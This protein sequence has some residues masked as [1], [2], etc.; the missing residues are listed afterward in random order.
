VSAA[1]QKSETKP[2]PP[3]HVAVIM[4]GNGRWAKLRGLPRAA[5]HQAGAEA[6]RRTLRTCIELGIDYLT[7]FAFSSENWKR[8][9]AEVDDLM[10]LLRFYLKKE[11]SHLK[12]RGIHL[13]FLGDRTGLATDILEIMAH[14]E[15][16]TADGKSLNVTVALNYGGRDEIIRAVRTLAKECCEGKLTPE[17]I[18]EEMLAA[19]LDTAGVPD[20]D[21]IVRTSGEQR[22]SNFLSWQSA[23][24]E[25]V[26]IP[27]L[28]PDFGRADMEAA[29]DEYKQRDRRYGAVAVS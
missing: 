29:I 18:D 26:F 21:L 6:L 4:D 7:V 13:G 12:G 16:E 17:A 23:Y 10:G 1:E 24:S 19:R 22:L 9:E 20:P 2:P 27:V 28:W 11:I 25:M 5:G 14:A 15:R 3:Q 8:P